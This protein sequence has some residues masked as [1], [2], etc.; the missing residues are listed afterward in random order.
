ML[1]ITCKGWVPVAWWL[2]CWTVAPKVNKLKPYSSFYVYFQMEMATQ[3][4]ILNKTVYISLHI[5]ELGEDMYSSL[6]P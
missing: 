3:F 1:Y 2:M 5:N 4:K 6:S